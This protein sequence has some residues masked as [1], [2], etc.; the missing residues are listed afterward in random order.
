MSASV[1]SH[2]KYQGLLLVPVPSAL[3]L[4]PDPPHCFLRHATSEEWP[5]F[6]ARLSSPEGPTL[7]SELA[8]IMRRCGALFGHYG[9]KLNE[10]GAALD[11]ALAMAFRHEPELMSATPP[12]LSAVFLKFNLDP[13]ANLHFQLVL[14]LAARYVPGFQRAYPVPPRRSRLP[15]IDVSILVLSVAK[16]R[17]YCEQQQLKAGDL[18]IANLLLDSRTMAKIVGPRRAKALQR[19]LERS[20]NKKWGY[21]RSLSRSAVIGY[22]RDIRLVKDAL[23][24]GTMN[25]F[26]EQ[27]FFRAMPA[28]EAWAC[29]IAPN[30]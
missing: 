28:I 2:R 9:K 17:D 20:G 5:T 19:V 15:T 10:P 23:D 7:H 1:S 29:Q 6:R 14:A 4:P 27:V 25:G 26:Q 12:A 13:D 11:V 8:Q 16:V 3:R 22:V 24:K 21:P 30:D 18:T